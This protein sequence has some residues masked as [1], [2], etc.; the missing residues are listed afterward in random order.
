MTVTFLLN[1][2]QVSLEIPPGKRLVDVLREDFD[3]KGNRPGC[4]AGVC[5]TCAVLL[6]GELA[7]SCMV[8]AFA[9]QLQIL[10]QRLLFL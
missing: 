9:V 7:Y 8:P 10:L 2:K 4:Y 3:L 6:N 5:G 1:G